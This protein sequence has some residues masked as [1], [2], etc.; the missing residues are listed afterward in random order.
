MFVHLNNNIICDVYAFVQNKPCTV[1]ARMFCIYQYL[2]A[3]KPPIS[4]AHDFHDKLYPNL[5]IEHSVALSYEN[6]L[7]LAVAIMTCR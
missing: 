4:C 2:L 1:I 7:L 6:Q 5:L 3:T